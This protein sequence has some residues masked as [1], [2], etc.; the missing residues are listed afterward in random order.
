MKNAKVSTASVELSKR[1]EMLEA[2][3]LQEMEYLL[4][5][6]DISPEKQDN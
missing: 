4:F 5:E 1:R 2:I 6:A 3:E